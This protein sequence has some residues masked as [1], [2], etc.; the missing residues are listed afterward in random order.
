MRK[1]PFRPI[2]WSWN[3][4]WKCT[5]ARSQRAQREQQRAERDHA[6]Q[7]QHQRRQPVRHQHDAEGRLPVRRQV[8]ADRARHAAADATD[9]SSD[10]CQ[11][12][13]QPR[14]ASTL[15]AACARRR[16][17]PSSS[18]SA[19]RTAADRQRRSGAAIQVDWRQRGR[20]MHGSSARSSSPST[21]SVP[22]QAARGQQHDEEQRRGREA[23]DDGREHQRLRHRVGV[24]L[25]GPPARRRARSARLSIERLPMLKM[26]RLTAYESSVSPMITWKVRGRSSSQTP[27]PPSTPM[28]SAST[29]PSA[30]PPL[31]APARRRARG[32][33]DRL[34]RERREDQQ[35]RARRPPRTR[36]CRRSV[37]L[38]R[39]TSPTQRQVHVRGVRGQEGIAERDRAEA[40][41]AASSSPTAIQRAGWMRSVR[42]HPLASRDDVLREQRD[43]DAPGRRR[44]RRPARCARAGRS[45]PRPRQAIG[46]SRRTIT[47]G[48]I[49]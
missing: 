2:S 25:R 31:A 46:S 3:S 7:H 20:S 13:A 15:T 29:I 8:D 37:A 44:S 41:G 5:P 1:A 10:G 33:A 19:A 26:N 36:R 12:Q 45:T 11:R 27:E 24:V 30:A 18:I 6:G 21:W 17:S 42:L 23:D 47:A 32:G 22:R 34:V 35:R 38:G 49:M 9:C 43:R 39:C 40:G 14:D 4:G 16:R 28:T 48:T